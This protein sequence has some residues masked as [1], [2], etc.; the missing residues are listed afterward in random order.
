MA[1]TDRYIKEYKDS[2]NGENPRFLWELRLTDK[3]YTELRRQLQENLAK[4]AELSFKTASRDLVIYISE[5]WRRTYNAQKP[6]YEMI[7][8]DLGLSPGDNNR[9]REACKSGYG[10]L[11]LQKIQTAGNQRTRDNLL[12]SMLYQGGLPMNYIAQDVKDASG[13]RRFFRDLAWKGQDFSLISESDNRKT[14][15]LSESI[16]EFCNNL[17]KA[18]DPERQDIGIL[19]FYYNEGWWKIIK[20]EIGEGLKEHRGRNPFILT[21]DILMDDREKSFSLAIR[22][23]GPRILSESFLEDHKI[24][25]RASITI[26][27]RINEVI[28][29]IAEYDARHF[30]RRSVGLH[31][32][33]KEGD[34]VSLFIEETEEIL[35]NR[36]LIFSEPKLLSL[37]DS[38]TNSFGVCNP[39]DLASKDCR[40]I[41]TSDWSCTGLEPVQ[42]ACKESGDNY[43]VFKFKTQAGSVSLVSK[44]GKSQIFSPDS[45][46]LNTEIDS[47]YALR[48]SIPVREQIFNAP[49]NIGFIEVRGE[50][51]L[52][53]KKE[54]VIYLDRAGKKLDSRIPRGPIRATFKRDN[55]TAA[56]IQFINTGE[57]KIECIESSR[58]SCKI[59]ISWQYGTASFMSDE[60][61]KAGENDC[62]EIEKE[63][64]RDKRHAEFKFQPQ[65]GEAFV[66]HILPPFND[67]CIYDRNGK[68][69]ST[70]AIIPVIDIES[71]RYFLN[72]NDNLILSPGRRI[73]AN[74]KY[75]YSRDEDSRYNTVSRTYY[76]SPTV[77]NK[78]PQEGSLSSLF[79]NGSELIYSLLEQSMSSLP[80][81]EASI[82][83]K[84]GNTPQIYTFKDFPY[85]LSFNDGIV[86]V[87]NTKHLPQ[88][89]G[90]LLAIPIE[91]P[92]NEPIEIYADDSGQ[93]DL[94]KALG[95][96]TYDKWLIYGNL[97]GYILP[98]MFDIAEDN[99]IKK[100]PGEKRRTY[101]ENASS[102]LQQAICFDEIWLRTISW[103]NLL[104]NGQI[105]GSSILELVAISEDRKLLTKF[106]LQY[107]LFTGLNGDNLGTTESSFLEFQRQMA[108]SW[109]WSEAPDRDRA[110]TFIATCQIDRLINFVKPQY[111]NWVIEKKS[112]DTGLSDY[113]LNMDNH[114]K[115]FID[116]FA[117]QFS[118]WFSIFRQNC[119]TK[120]VL[121]HPDTNAY[122]NTEFEGV[123]HPE[124]QRAFKTFGKSLGNLSNDA[125]WIKERQSFNDVLK[126][127]NLSDYLDRQGIEHNEYIRQE[128][129][130]SI[131][132]GL[133]FRNEDY[134]I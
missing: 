73:D 49:D 131:L 71:Y 106:A 30:S 101:L 113:Y 14:I 100:Q 72:L 5:W 33:Y 13:W 110:Q 7:C 41:A 96:K 129:R 89:D 31:L 8:G 57:I 99:T 47:A 20:K 126:K 109:D 65:F 22:I 53:I 79:T 42:Y 15:A 91:K 43:A 69:I 64:L 3:Q 93:Y 83:I 32:Q 134:E 74:S 16:R 108:I 127:E 11:G 17:Q 48:T 52:P 78:V 132:Y 120:D 12:L 97:R 6:S 24:K 114:I 76:N 59:K 87:D 2:H 62:W 51:E 21:W 46:A 36:Q 38:Q 85:H 40:V 94:Q 122:S 37:T 84:Y 50:R 119:S 115:E 1:L 45:Q 104:A 70:K 29:P 81:A 56:S 77:N 68:E 28:Y 124:A 112:Q 102:E 34:T 66:L 75:T 133:K 19:P 54:D 44:D 10:S 39:S 116:D 60:G 23:S 128:I 123:T 26:S 4:G 90:Y 103:F 18:A 121:Q 9:L 130:K 125:K 111:Y 80:D 35:W 117:S 82:A 92:D 86:R 88:Y 58:N 67:F 25:D 98:K 105:P 118:V 61:T 63:T 55:S 95:D 107:A 27:A